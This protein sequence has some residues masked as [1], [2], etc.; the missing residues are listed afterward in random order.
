VNG[1]AVD[2]ELRRLY[3]AVSAPVSTVAV[4]SLPELAFQGELVKGALDLGSEP[5][6]AILRRPDG[7][8]WLYVTAD[9]SVSIYDAHS[10]A[11]I[12]R[13]NPGVGVETLVADDREQ[14]LY[15]PDENGG[16]GVYAFEPL[17]A[18]RRRGGPPHFGAEVFD[19]DAEGIVL[20]R[21]PPDASSD[22]GAGFLV[23]ADQRGSQTEFEF[24]E[25]RSGRHLGALRLAGVAN[26]DGIA[27]TQRALPGWPLG[28]FAAIDD[29]T[30]AAVIG[31][32]RILE[33][34]GLA[35]PGPEEGATAPARPER[36]SP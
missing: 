5:N 26:T 3:L 35:C 28:V 36:V 15:V 6:L 24:F 1:I 31:W 12:G 32:H 25:R 2:Q 9:T 20:Y 30:T 17:G 11:A 13:W 29:D 22:D 19:E 14:V 27:S 33:A 23:V 4:F 8:R 21:C 18:P 10:G 7:A 16:S 34:T